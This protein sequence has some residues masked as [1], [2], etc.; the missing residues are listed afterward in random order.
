VS[1]AAL[2]GAAAVAALA[3]VDQSSDDRS[4]TATPTATATAAP[5][6]FVPVRRDPNTPAATLAEAR[7]QALARL[8]VL[9]RPG[10]PSDAPSARSPWPGGGGPVEPDW[11]QVRRVAT[12][13][14]VSR[15]GTVKQF[16]MPAL[17]D[18]KPGFCLFT[19][20]RHGSGLTS[21]TAGL[22]TA[23][24]PS[25]SRTNTGGAPLYFV[26]FPDGVDSVTLQLKSGRAIKRR[27]A[28][29]ALLFQQRGLDQITWRDSSGRE[30]RKRLVV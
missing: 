1:V 9:R 4:V 3:G 12:L 18:G 29:N 26:L 15:L 21:C 22:P 17:W 28:N 25:W 10:R 8:G 6:P 24:Y 20:H 27:V 13:A 19:E 7:A 14:E 23:A 16:V 2:A 5:N 11:T 30:Y